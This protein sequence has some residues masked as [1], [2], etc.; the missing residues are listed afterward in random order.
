MG[1]PSECWNSVRGVFRN[2]KIV[3]ADL[4]KRVRGHEMLE[5][6][7]TFP[8]NRSLAVG[9]TSSGP[10]SSSWVSGESKVILPDHMQEKP[11]SLRVGPLRACRG[12]PGCV[13]CG[14][15][16]P[17]SVHRLPSA[18]GYGQRWDVAKVC[19]PGE[20]EGEVDGTENEHD[21]QRWGPTMYPSL[22]LRIIRDTTI[23][24][25]LNTGLSDLRGLFHRRRA[26]MTFHI[27]NGNPYWRAGATTERR[28]TLC[29][30]R[31]ARLQRWE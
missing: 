31:S 6:P 24:H 27:L 11:G 2:P 14:R 20:D 21:E 9:Y 5:I 13:L 12:H 1:C 8:Q 4:G 22:R 23:H 30:P 26:Y 15:V 28:G 3:S 18:F 25:F 29:S 10:M 17:L 7:M 16:S 19:K